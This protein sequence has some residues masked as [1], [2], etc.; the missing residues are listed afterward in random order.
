MVFSFLGVGPLSSFSLELIL[1]Y[2]TGLLGWE[3]SI[4]QDIYLRRKTQI[5]VHAPSKIRT[6]DP[7]VRAV[8]GCTCLRPRGQDIRF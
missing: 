5:S 4:A 6:R 1:K 8:Q 3:N 2:R 7:S